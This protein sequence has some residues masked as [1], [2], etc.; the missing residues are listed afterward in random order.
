MWLRKRE[1]LNLG[2]GLGTLHFT[3]Y[4]DSGSPFTFLYQERANFVFLKEIEMW[5]WINYFP[6]HSKVRKQLLNKCL[7]SAEGTAFTH[8]PPPP[9]PGLKGR[10]GFGFPTAFIMD[11]ILNKKKEIVLNL[12]FSHL[13]RWEILV[14]PKKHFQCSGI[15]SLWN[16]AVSLWQ[17]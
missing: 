8:F 16:L 12:Y 7:V 3:R 9:T 11:K 14:R 10:G 15:W 6:S 5:G 4:F 17:F 1:L 2:P 13:M